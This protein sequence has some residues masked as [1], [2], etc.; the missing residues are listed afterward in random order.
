MNTKF[1]EYFN[2][3]IIELAT[4]FTG[5]Q[6]QG[7]TTKPGLTQSGNTPTQASPA[8][9]SQAQ[10]QLSLQ[11]QILKIDSQIANLLKAKEELTKKMEQ[12]DQQPQ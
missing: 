9:S 12:S 6:P 7:T 10:A 5:N 4:G 3:L 1:N 2:S 8:T 11:Q